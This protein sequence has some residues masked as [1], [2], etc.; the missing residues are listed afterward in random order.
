MPK[1]DLEQQRKR[2]KDLRRAHARGDIEAADRIVRHLPRA[3][4]QSHQAVLALRFTLSEA[5]LVVAR[6][7]GYPSWPQ[8]RRG[9]D[10]GSTEHSLIEAALRGAHDLLARDGEAPAAGRSIYLVAAL[11]D[12]SAARSM[13]AHDASLADR[14]GGP[15]DWTPLLYACCSR[16][17]NEARIELARLLL[18]AGADVNALGREPGFSS[19]NVSMLDG[20]EWRPIEGAAAVADHEL[21][22]LLVARGAD[23]NLT[24][25]FLTRAV[26]SGDREILRIALDAKPPWWQVTWALCACVELERADMAPVLVAHAE[27]ARMREPALTDAIRLHRDRELIDILL[28]DMPSPVWERAYRAAARYDHR[29]A[30]ALLQQR[31]LSAAALTPIDRAIAACIAGASDGGR[32][33][34]TTAR[35]SETSADRPVTTARPIARGSKA[36][37]FDDVDHRMLAWAVRS[38]RFAAVPRLLAIGL[39]PN[40]ADA[41]GQTPLHLAV[42]AAHDATIDTLLR[43]GATVDARDYDARTPLELALALT[44]A[45]VRDRLARR[46][47]AAGAQ[48][49]ELHHFT[50]GGDPLDD[51]LRRAGAIERSD[52]AL[53]FERAADAVVFGDLDTLRDLLDDEPAL[54]HARS[55]RPHRATLLNYCGA[56][57]TEDP[58]QRTP[59]N[60]PAIAEL[61][62][63]RG[64]DPNAACKLYRGGSTTMD[65][66]VTSAI[67]RDA[68]LD[69]ELVRVLARYGAKLR[70]GDLETAITHN[71][72]NA[73][74]ALLE[75]GIPIDNIFVAAGTGQLDRLCALL[76]R[77]ADIDARFAGGCT[78]LHAAAATNQAAC[79]RVLLDR[80]AA[81]TLRDD[82]FGTTPAQWAAH[83]G[84][85]EL[86]RVLEG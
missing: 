18:D 80:G 86:A 74:A 85:D 59:P 52:E 63:Q 25:A 44:D 56:N 81:R 68:G 6:E 75:A 61:L 54:V 37:A 34:D 46:L 60:A 5:Q 82:T 15:R 65:L 42:L 20:Y 40:A 1:L 23:P 29:E 49:G 22:G 11:G 2:A 14:R 79:A 55:P 41:D 35:G 78:A 31:G 17:N 36:R 24:S 77:G 64:A 38:R 50:S 10:A 62:L 9:I 19:G 48:P 84:H 27:T 30:I 39:D 26:Q 7:A 47:L 72:P 70:A 12:A 83:Y 69:G 28:G 57:G 32:T 66:L 58:R 71:A 33:H 45:T 21:L 4:G 67:P 16:T 3:A 73:I 51:E 53:L 13:L 43:A 76:D 8:L